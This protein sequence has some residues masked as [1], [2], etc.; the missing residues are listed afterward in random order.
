MLDSVAVSAL[1]PTSLEP[2]IVRIGKT[3]SKDLLSQPDS[4]AMQQNAELP[5]S[6]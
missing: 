1:Q 3:F 5:T 2:L 6:L 4:T